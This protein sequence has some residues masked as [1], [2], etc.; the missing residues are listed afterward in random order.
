V[1][2]L[3]AD[4]DTKENQDWTKCWIYMDLLMKTGLEIWIVGYLQ[5]GMCLI[6]LE[7]Q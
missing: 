2:L 7:E 4:C 1:A 5:V 6:C 3:A